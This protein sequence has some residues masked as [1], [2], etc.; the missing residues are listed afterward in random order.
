MWRSARRA[1]SGS[2]EWYRKTETARPLL[3]DSGRVCYFNLSATGLCVLGFLFGVDLIAHGL[4]WLICAAK[5]GERWAQ[6]RTK[7]L[8]VAVILECST[9]VSASTRSAFP[10]CF[11]NRSAL[12]VRLCA[13][14]G[15]NARF[16]RLVSVGST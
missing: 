4:G 3:R 6:E 13:F 10:R 9:R 2:Y 16:A 8:R 11:S 7:S 12:A 15:C 5:R 14:V 1:R